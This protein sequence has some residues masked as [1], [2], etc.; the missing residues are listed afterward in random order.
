[1]HP[2]PIHPLPD[3]LINQIAAG[4]VV[5]RPASIVKELIENSLDAGA[6]AIR[7]EI[8]GGGIDYIAVEDDGCGIPRE[9]LALALQRHC[10][11]KITQAA[12]LNGI[13]SL[14]FRGEALA[15][16]TAVA[17]VTLTSRTFDAAY[18]YT[19]HAPPGGA[20]MAPSPAGRPPGTTI[21]VRD[22]F[23]NI[24][25]RRA[26][27]RRPTTELLSIQQLVRGIAFC[28]PGVSFTLNYA[29]RRQWYAPAAQDDRTNALRWRAIF[30][31]EFAREARFI[32][33]ATSA[34]RVHGWIGPAASARG[35]AD[36]QFLAVN[37]RLIR[38][39][40][41]LHAIR[42]AFGDALAPGR[43]MCFAV[44]LEIDPAAVDVNVHP[45]KTEVR[46]RQ[47]REVHDLLY[48]ATRQALAQDAS[49][50]AAEPATYARNVASTHAPD[51][52]EVRAAPPV[53]RP[54]TE[55]ATTDNAAG[56]VDTL[57]ECQYLPMLSENGSLELIDVLSLVC[58]V[59]AAHQ[60]PADARSLSFPVRVPTLPRL[61][62]DLALSAF[63]QLG[64][65]FAAIGPHSWVL[66][67]VPAALPELDGE[68]L[69]ASLLRD[70]DFGTKPP[71]AAARACT[72]ALRIPDAMPARRLWA[73][74]WHAELAA[75]S[76]DFAR[77]RRV[78]NA[79][80]VAHVFASMAPSSNA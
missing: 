22:L 37:G 71:V 69:V 47:V 8:R 4:E 3:Q 27:L 57:I 23:A 1:M 68:I 10:T 18:A 16:I 43:Y 31:A 25:A 51:V 36:L 73:A 33:V 80:T 50:R 64:L 28:S 52:A 45:N 2:R 12:D 29:Q 66:R 42:T 15:S 30:G 65:E 7:V 24:P 55:V 78:L 53:W 32:D 9:Q 41:L 39:R 62:P 17:D 77:H 40:Q 11:S 60:A 26:F 48:A 46:F 56:T 74:R 38:D 67:T 63:A 34:L 61:G 21:T 13:V 49:S 19:V 54:I 35:Q 70:P 72:R 14:G 5:E 20:L 58:E 59:L 75:R 6:G 44:H 79:A 76:I